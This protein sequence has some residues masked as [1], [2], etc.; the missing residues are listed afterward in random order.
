ML[1]LHKRVRQRGVLQQVT[2]SLE[3]GDTRVDITV[4]QRVQEYDFWNR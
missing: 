4:I 3:D 2:N 1:T